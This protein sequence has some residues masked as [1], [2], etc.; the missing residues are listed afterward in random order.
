MHSRKSKN[1]CPIAIEP[2]T[3][4]V[5]PTPA[6]ARQQVV[7][8]GQSDPAAARRH[9]SSH[10]QAQSP[11]QGRTQQQLVQ[12]KDGVRVSDVRISDVIDCDSTA[13]IRDDPFFRPYQSPHSTRLATQSRLAH[14]VVK[15]NKDVCSGPLQSERVPTVPPDVLHVVS[16]LLLGK[17]SH[18][19]CLTSSTASMQTCL[20]LTSLSWGA[21]GSGSQPLSRRPWTFEDMLHQRCQARRCRL[22]ESS[23]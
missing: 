22:T 21:P 8:R 1:S 19:N 3:K 17:N 13:S 7:D 11:S 18:A 5:K 14:G 4:A 2:T 16:R 20:R 9:A 15:R 23:T 6:N 12:R 10:A